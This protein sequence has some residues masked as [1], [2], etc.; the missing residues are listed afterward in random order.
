MNFEGASLSDTALPPILH[1][2]EQKDKL[3]V[4][5][6]LTD[7]LQSVTEVVVGV[8]AVVEEGC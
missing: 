1:Y 4:Y 6:Q 5:A 2:V 7:N 3:D 8:D